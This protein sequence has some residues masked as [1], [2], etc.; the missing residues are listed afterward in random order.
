[1]Q[2]Q[3]EVK[4]LEIVVDRQLED[5]SNQK[6][7]KAKKNKKVKEE[8]VICAIYQGCNRISAQQHL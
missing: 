4:R 7:D 5:L 8:K 3:T 1:M 6:A 2:K